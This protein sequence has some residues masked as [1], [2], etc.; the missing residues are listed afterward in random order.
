MSI[1]DAHNLNLKRISRCYTGATDKAIDFPWQ[2][3]S[4]QFDLY[5]SFFSYHNQCVLLPANTILTSGK[6][7]IPQAYE[8]RHGKFSK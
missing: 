2:M 3:S 5:T 6:F 8:K 7:Q 4:R 1:T